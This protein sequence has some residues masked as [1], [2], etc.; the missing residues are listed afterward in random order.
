[1]KVFITGAAGFVAGHFIELLRQ[2]EP[3]AEIFGLARPQ[4]APSQVPG[5]VTM[6][7]ADLLE[8]GSVEAA[9]S[10]AQPDR[11]VHL[12]AQSSPMKSWSD[13]QATL[14]TNILGTQ[15]LLEAARKCRTPPRILLVGSAEEYGLAS[16]SEIP[17]R[18][19]APLRPTSPYAVSKIAAGYL[20][21]QYALAH[22]LP[23]VRTRTF[24]HTGP[25]RSEAFAESSFARQIVE[26]EL[27][28]RPPVLAVGNLDAIRDFADVRDTVRAYGLL[29]ERGESGEVYNVCSGRGQRIRELL[30][31]L[32]K[33]SGARVDVR[34][35]ESRLRPSDIPVL[36]GDPAKLNKAT[37]W[38]PRI[39]LERTLRD[40]LNDW[41][42]RLGGRSSTA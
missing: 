42:E 25:G 36:V 40:L 13:P 33:L 27:K 9:V 14:R 20:G 12:A 31:I 21:L 38:T 35:D 30:D 17:L 29:L 16:P 41:R 26:I 34:V 7:E 24:H 5:R 2:E 22:R 19:E 3:E 15:N 1:V 39:P 23:V 32:L 10:L 11:I 6:I 4:G 37:G 8:A 28:R 18:E